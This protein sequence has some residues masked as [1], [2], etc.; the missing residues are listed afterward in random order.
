MFNPGD[1]MRRIFGSR[2][3]RVIKG[4]L[5]LVAAVNAL[6]PRYEA[7]TDAQLTAKTAEFKERLAGGATLDDLLPEAFAAAREAAKRTLGLR[8]FDV[9][10]M[11]GIAMHR[12][13]ISEMMTGEGKTLTSVAPAYLNALTGRGVHIVTVNDYLA[14]RGAA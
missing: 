11:G 3:E 13:S 1:W 6:E 10:V 12:G 5:P 7:L 4:T 2:N 9:Q 8:L 14:R